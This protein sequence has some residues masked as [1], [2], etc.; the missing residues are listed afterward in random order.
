MTVS[1]LAANEGLGFLFALSAMLALKLLIRQINLKGLL[2][3]KQGASEVSPERVQLLLATLAVSATYL[4]S[5]VHS[6]D[7]RMPDVPATSLYLFGS[8]SGL[9]ALVKGFTIWKASGPRRRARWQ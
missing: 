2:A 7:G 6:S 9:Y 3:R 8:S 5:V 1:S 4:A